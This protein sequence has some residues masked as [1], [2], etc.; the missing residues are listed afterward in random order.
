MDFTNLMLFVLLGI[1]LLSGTSIFI[2]LALSVL[3]FLNIYTQI[4]V[5][6]II[7]R[8]FAGLDRF[9]M[10]CVPF[11]ILAAN[12]AGVGGI[13]RRIINVSKT[14]VGHFKGGL[15]MTTVLACTFFGAISGSA[16]A[17]VIAIGKILYPALIETGYGK[18]F[19]LGVITSS[20]AIA[21]I[22]PPSITMIVLGAVCGMSIGALF[23][24]G[25]GAG[26]TIA[27]VFMIYCYFYARNKDI[28]LS[29]RATLR[30][31]G[32]A[33]WDAKW[34]LG[35][36]ILIIGGIYGGVF[37]PTEASGVAATYTLFVAQFIHRE[38]SSREI[39]RAIV[40]SAT[41]SAQ[42]M[43]ILAGASVFS[44]AVT[45]SQLSP[46]IAQWVMGMSSSPNMVLV[47]INIV[48]LIAGCL[49]DSVSSSII[50]GPLLYPAVVGAGIDPIHFGIITTVNLSIGMFTPPFGLNLFV[51]TVVPKEG[52]SMSQIIRGVAVFIAISM[53]ALAIVT[54]V[55][56]ISLWLPR[57][58]G[59]MK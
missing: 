24:S 58:L 57:T 23:V 28:K 44:W 10:L 39:F 46:L 38:V 50:L 34:A 9:A 54:Y 40:D 42:I 31:I 20:G 22:I 7:E 8:Q 43:I 5:M 47:L 27:L 45:T 33:C 56:S 4:P 14:L 2:S 52:A 35:V 51:A 25:F 3:L 16:P 13:S 1:L 49:V 12:I 26:I 17:T 59:M 53:I 21:L 32:A 18:K 15:A 41:V 48:F 36:P 29:K 19:S 11:F 55:P 6:G 30:E 37:T